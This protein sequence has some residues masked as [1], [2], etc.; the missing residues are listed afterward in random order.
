MI[1][2]SFI[3]EKDIKSILNYKAI[4][5]YG[6]NEGLKNDIKINLKKNFDKFDILNYFQDEII[7]KENILLQEIFNKSLF[8]REKIILLIKQATKLLIS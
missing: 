3:L 2:K 4:L 5:F 8:E 6:E 7:K 1:I